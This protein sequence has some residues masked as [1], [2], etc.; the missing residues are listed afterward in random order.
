MVAPRPVEKLDLGNDF[1]PN[2]Y[3]FHLRTQNPPAMFGCVPVHAHRVTEWRVL[4]SE[5]N[6]ES[7]RITSSSRG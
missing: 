4:R 2:P 5:D 7:D 6:I 1:G 3:I